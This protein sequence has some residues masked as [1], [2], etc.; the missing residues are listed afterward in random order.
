M[1]DFVEPA[2]D[3]QLGAVITEALHGILHPSEQ[4]RKTLAALADDPVL[5]PLE[6]LHHGFRQDQGD[7]A[8]FH[9]GLQAGQSSLL[10]MIFGQVEPDAGVYKQMKHGRSVAR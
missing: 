10:A 9:Q 8:L 7:L 3:I 4:A 5:V 2:H 1:I 6:L